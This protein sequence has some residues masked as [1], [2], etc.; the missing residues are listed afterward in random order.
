MSFGRMPLA[1]A[2]LTPDQF[3]REYF[4]EMTPAFC[5]ACGMFQITEQPDPK[6]MFHD[7]YAFFTRTSKG[8]VAH[9]QQYAQWVQT[10][11]AP[12]FV[13]EIGCN[14]GAMLENFASGGVQ[15]LGVEP[16]ANVAAVAEKHGIRTLVAF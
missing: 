10:R 1:N 15:H 2:F 13:V 7:A 9:F 16:S 5:S 4:Y 12:K 11:F 8:M 6:Q 3:D 14:D